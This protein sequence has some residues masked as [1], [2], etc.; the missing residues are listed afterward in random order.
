MREL[1]VKLM[2]LAAGMGSRLGD[3]GKTTPKCLLEVG[4]KT[5]LE[6]ILFRAKEAGINNVVIKYLS[7]S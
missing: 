4:G 2:I 6:Y 1:K 7:F 3:V 5:L